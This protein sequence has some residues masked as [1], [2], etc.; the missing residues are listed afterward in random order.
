[1][2]EKKRQT[3]AEFMAELERDPDFRRMRAAKDEK[4]RR[5]KER[6]DKIE[7][8][9][10]G[11]LRD[12]GFPAESIEDL[13]NK[14]APL[15]QDAVDL[16]IDSL[17][18]CQEYRIQESLVRAL[19]AADSPFDGR[20]L[21]DCFESTSSEGVRFAILNTIALAKPH[22]IDDWLKKAF[23]NDYLRQTLANLGH[24][25]PSAYEPG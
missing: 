3:A 19:G 5:L 1:M 11:R 7:A 16:L 8:P 14:Y 25:W 13:V 2:S 24:K 12:A 20:P 4:F 10:L 15:P 23:Q 21:V 18:T 9:I 17:K 6:L 22:S